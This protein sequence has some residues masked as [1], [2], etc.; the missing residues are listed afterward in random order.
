MQARATTT[1]Y[2]HRMSVS[3][4][5]MSYSQTT[6]LEIYGKHNYPHTDENTL[7]RQ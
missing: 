5:A 7:T 6:V 4:D 1:A 2:Q 3:G